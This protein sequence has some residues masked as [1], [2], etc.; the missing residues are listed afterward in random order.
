MMFKRFLS[1]IA[2]CAV[3]VFS[4]CGRSEPDAD[5]VSSTVGVTSG[6]TS[7]AASDASS[8]AAE[9]SS[10]ESFEVTPPFFK[11]T[12]ESTGAV[13]YMLGSMHVGKPG[14]SYPQELFDAIDEC[15]TLAVEVDIQALETDIAAMTEA[16][17]LMLCPKGTTVK[18]YMGEDY[19]EIIREFRKKDLYN[20][21]YEYYIPSMWS[22]LWSNKAAAE[23]G[24]DSSIGTDLI[25][26]SY[27]KEH[28]KQI[29]EIESARE[30]YQME[31]EISPELQML[32][33]KQTLKLSQEE[34]QEQFDILY[35]AWRTADTET[36]KKL[37][38][39]ESNEEL[40]EELEAD[41]QAY[42]DAMYTNRQK[43]MSDYVIGE[44]NAGRKT[45][46]V[47]GAMHYAA[48][49]SILDNL[50]ESGYEIEYLNQ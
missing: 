32:T 19:N 38:E 36:L 12:D 22:S 11:V 17:Q 14:A 7:N 43:K 8:D 9:S 25:L 41:Y 10:V 33:L 30:Q 6:G 40:S 29:D 44:L 15:D 49:P 16:V 39:D 4:G 2:A 28:G 3:L 23:C 34:I 46:V 47:V 45:F 31:A 48:P 42:Y 26:L 24:F 1:V 13:V 18:D 50:A 21:I 37:A 27:A 20:P 5:P 35:D